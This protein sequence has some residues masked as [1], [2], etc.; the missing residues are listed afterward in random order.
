MAAFQQQKQSAYTRL[1]GGDRVAGQDGVSSIP[2][3]FVIG[4]EGKILLREVG[5]APG[6]GERAG[7]IIARHLAENANE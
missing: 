2:T 4:V 1:V 7:A 6:M 5:F 3:F